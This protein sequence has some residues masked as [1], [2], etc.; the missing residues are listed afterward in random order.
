MIMND[1]GQ[2]RA[3][4]E[5]QSLGEAGYEA[6]KLL[7]H[8]HNRHHGHV[9]RKPVCIFRLMINVSVISDGLIHLNISTCL[10]RSFQAKRVFL[11]QRAYHVH[12]EMIVEHVN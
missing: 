1:G 5:L 7:I 8:Y 3:N 2:S 10:Y 6:V 4:Q 9:E 11:F 12:N